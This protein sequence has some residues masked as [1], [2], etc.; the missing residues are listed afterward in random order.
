[1]IEVSVIIPTYNR[2]HVLEKAL[3]ALFSQTYPR[4]SYEVVVVDDGSSDGTEEM[5]G[6]AV[7]EAPCEF[8]YLRQ[9]K[10][11]PAAARNRGITEAKGETVLFLGDDIVADKELLKEHI[12]S[13]QKSLRA[14]QAVLGFTTWHPEVKRTTFI[15]YLD[16]TD[17]QFG[18]GSME[19]PEDLSYHYFYSSNISLKREFLLQNG[20]FDEDFKYPAY[21]DS[22]LGYRLKK[23]G[24]W[25]VLNRRAIAYHLHQLTYSRFRKRQRLA[26]YGAALFEAKH[27]ELKGVL[28]RDLEALFGGVP[29]TGWAMLKLRIKEMLIML[30]EWLHLPE[31]VFFLDPFSAYGVL[32]MY[33]FYLGVAGGPSSVPE[34]L[35]RHSDWEGR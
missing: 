1:M 3:R 7:G 27:P 19:A 10:R 20:I 22:E 17:L 21:E 6:S 35:R 28:T 15:S 11:G 18:Y 13:H 30:H 2:K 8:R 5:V 9:E 25:I 32:L 31:S 34:S 26:G 23:R 14:N 4:S 24:L 29:P 33:H 12:S 16:S